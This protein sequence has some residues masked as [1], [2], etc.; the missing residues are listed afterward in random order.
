MRSGEPAPEAALIIGNWNGWRDTLECLQN[1]LRPDYLAYRVLVCD[2]G[3]Q[4][5]S[6]GYLEA[7]ADRCLDVAVPPE[8]HRPLAA[9]DRAIR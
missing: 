4:D 8:G 9:P 6:I 3:S 5:A 7:W 2:N 1:V